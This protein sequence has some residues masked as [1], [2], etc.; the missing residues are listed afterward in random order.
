MLIPIP[1]TKNEVPQRQRIEY[2]DAL[3]GFTNDFG[4]DLL[5]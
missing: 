1:H 4:C 5:N 2:L 3:R